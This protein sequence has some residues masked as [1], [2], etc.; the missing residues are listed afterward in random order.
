MKTRV[1]QLITFEVGPA[2]GSKLQLTEEE[3]DRVCQEAA[4]SILFGNPFDASS[5][6]MVKSDQSYHGSVLV[7]VAKVSADELTYIL[8]DRRRLHAE[9]VRLHAQ[10]EVLRAFIKESCDSPQS[11]EALSI[12]EAVNPKPKEDPEETQG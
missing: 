9:N 4:E 12:A 2:L 10:R 11:V 5:H 7:T 1:V 6:A 8:L 3:A